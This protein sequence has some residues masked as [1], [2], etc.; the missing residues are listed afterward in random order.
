[1]NVQ[2]AGG[3]GVVGSSPVPTVAPDFEGFYASHPW[4]G[5]KVGD[6]QELGD[7]IFVQVFKNA[8][9]YSVLNHEPHEVHGAILT[10]YTTLGGPLGFLGAPTTDETS[11]A[12]GAGRFNHFENGSIYWHPSIG[13]FEV[14]GA[15]HEKWASLGFEK[16]GYPATDET[17]TPDRSG[18]FNH[19]QFAGQSQPA[20]SIYWTPS[21]GSHEIHGEI[22]TAWSGIGWET[23]FL[24]Y[25][26]SDEYSRDGWRLNDFQSGSIL[27]DNSGPQIRPQQFVSSAPSITFDSGTPVGGF[28]SLTLFSDGTTHF[29]GHLHDSGAP[30]YDCLAVFTVRD[31]DGNAYAASHSGTV[32]GTEVS[33]SRDLDWDDWGSNDEVRHNWAKIRSGG[34]GNY[35]VDVTSDWTIENIENVAKE[36]AEVAGTVIAIV[37][38]IFGGSNKSSD[39]NYGPDNSYPSGDLSPSSGSVG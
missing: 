29:Q 37:G 3:A 31:K 22:R 26:V 35:R 39:P 1:M 11:T 19:F 6:M 12:D 15:I 33:G 36:I 16:F 23:S 9:A 28:G 8:T 20:A 25:P 32:R 5:S 2:T 7:R 27:W 18:R 34:T 30:S 14:H 17:E 4:V 13:A 24:G 38:M 21:T 10:K